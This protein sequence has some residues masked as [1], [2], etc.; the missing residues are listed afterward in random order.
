[1]FLSHSVQRGNSA[2]KGLLL[3]SRKSLTNC[4]LHLFPS[5]QPTLYLRLL[6]SIC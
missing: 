2:I 3:Q 6:L 4:S 5:L 1:M